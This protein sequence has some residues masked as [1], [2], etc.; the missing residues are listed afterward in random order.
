MQIHNALDNIGT[1][2]NAVITIGSFD[3]VHRGH[4]KLIN[5][6]RQLAT[7]VN[8]E[9]VIVTFQP[10]P[11]KVIYPNDDT[12]S[13]LTS[14][15]EKMMLFQ[16]FGVDHVVIVPF[17]I[18]F[19]QQ[20]PGEYIEKFIVN[21]F[22]PSYI[23]IGYDHRFGL[24]RAGNIDFLRS[25]EEKYGYKVI[26]IPKQEIEDIAISS[27]KV[28]NAISNNE[29]MLAKDYLGYNYMLSGK[30]IHG[31]KIGTKIGYSTANIALDEKDKLLPSDGI[32]AVEVF[33]DDEKYNGMLYIG[34][35]P[36]IH[37][38]AN[39]TI[40]VHIF[41]FHQYIYDRKIRLEIIAFMRYDQKFESLDELKTALELDE[42]QA[43]E[44]LTKVV[45]KR[46]PEIAIAIL[47][48][49]GE[50]ILESYLPSTLYSSKEDVAFYIIDNQSTDESVS[51]VQKW[52]PEYNVIELQKNYGYAGGYN[53]GLKEVN[54]KYVALINSDI[55]C[56]EN[57]IDPIIEL[58]ESDDSIAAVQP[59]I[60]SIEHPDH[61][62]YAGASGGFLDY[63]AYP[64]CRGRIFTSIEKDEGQY[65]N[66]K[67][68]FWATGAAI[69]VRKEVFDKMG[70]FDDEYFAHQE[71]IDLCWRMKNA[72]YKVYCEPKS[73]VYHLGGAT[74]DYESP[75]K[76]FL[77]FKNN[78]LTLVKNE[79]KAWFWKFVI[80][81]F[82]D[83]IAGVQFL[84]NGNGKN[85]LAIIK[86][87][88][89]ILPK[90][91]S[92]IKRRK[93]NWEIIKQNR[94]APPN[95]TGYF[96]KSILWNYF[97]RKN[98]SFTNLR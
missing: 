12:L 31:E 58:M 94:I 39:K 18:E 49:N 6:I 52:H 87:H 13:L 47:N 23:V 65:D 51:Y 68:V 21:K 40:E 74:L 70:G 56:T 1:I 3:G 67:E 55:Q 61:F 86:A 43:R 27:T 17:T 5:K 25:Y 93:K 20:S 92:V 91:R 95:Y 34:N 10:H 89:S 26:Q 30:V 75:H 33:I 97:V 53:F 22:H 4:Q 46:T 38:E 11:R 16:K 64:F 71:E 81:L 50:E 41:D 42:L 62:E 29:M 48:Y 66:Q 15:E 2:K 7:E 80:R 35:K 69:V 82:L 72:G 14:I 83:G 45:E 85:A 28:R 90:F 78:L 37:S 19:S 77:N 59:K 24:N 96:R 79:R 63:L 57:W 73:V 98:K 8:G 36:T 60:L 9:S 54:E 32:Y 76:T 84:L 44:I 88:W